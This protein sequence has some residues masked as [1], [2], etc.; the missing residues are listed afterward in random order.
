MTTYPSGD[1]VTLV[2]VIKYILVVIFVDIDIGDIL[3]SWE[4]QPNSLTIRKIM[5]DDGREKLQIRI[6]LGV[7]QMETERSEERRVGKECRSR[8]SP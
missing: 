4:Y 7:L 5:G 3:G 6:S 8:W 1:I 2:R